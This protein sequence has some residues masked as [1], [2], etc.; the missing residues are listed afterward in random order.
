MEDQI[1]YQFNRGNDEVVQ[2]RFSEYKQRKYIDLRVFFR[3][4]NEDELRPTKKG[5]TVALDHFSELK[6]GIMT[7]EKKLSAHTF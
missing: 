6:K 2:F 5:I 4:K 1:L 7:C 3:L